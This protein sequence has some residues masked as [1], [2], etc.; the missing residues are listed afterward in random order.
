MSKKAIRRRW[1]ATCITV[2]AVVT[3]PALGLAAICDG[4]PDCQQQVQAPVGYSGWQTQSWAF[5]CL[6]GINPHQYFWGLA[7]GGVIEDFSFDNSCFTVTENIFAENSPQEFNALI[8]NWCINSQ[9]ITVT[10]G[11]STQPP[12]QAP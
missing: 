7:F 4:V 2:L 9:F 3:A 11:C 5:I 12:P 6:G 1:L 10:L 8:T